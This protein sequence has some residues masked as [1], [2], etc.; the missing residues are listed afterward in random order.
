MVFFHLELLQKRVIQEQTSENTGGI[1]SYLLRQI[2][3]VPEPIT[4]SYSEKIPRENS[5]TAKTRCQLGLS[6]EGVVW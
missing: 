3:L 5:V 2:P 1:P 4:I 6:Q